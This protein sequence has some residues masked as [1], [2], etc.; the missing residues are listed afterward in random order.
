[1]ETVPVE[2]STSQTTLAY[3]SL[4]NMSPWELR[5]TPN[6]PDSDAIV[7]GPAVHGAAALVARVVMIPVEP[8]TRRTL[9]SPSLAES[10]SQS[11]MKKSPDWSAAT[12]SVNDSG[13]EVAG[14]PSP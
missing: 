12:P 5:A 2:A 14:P 7:A 10:G 3:P 11:A 1:M 9:S 13:A 8:S 6:T 4:K